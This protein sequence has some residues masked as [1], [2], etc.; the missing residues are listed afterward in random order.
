[1][2]RAAAP[3]SA[4]DAQLRSAS[5]RSRLQLGVWWLL[6]LVGVAVVVAG[7]LLDAPRALTGLGAVAVTSAYTWGLVARTGGRQLVFSMLAAALG[8]TA[9]VTDSEHLRAGAAVLTCTVGAVLGVMATQ[10][11][12]RFVESAREVVL[13]MG[14]A[15]LGAVAAVGYAPTVSLWRFEYVTLAL[16]F[17]VVLT[18]VYRLGAGLHG[19]GRR[20]VGVVVVSTLVVG[21][22]LAYGEALRSLGTSEISAAV[23]DVA[24]WLSA[25][26][27][28]VPRPTQAHVG[29]PA[30]AWGVYLR[31][32]RRQGWWVCGFGVAATAPVG[33]SLMDP[34][35]TLSQAGLGLL[36]SI[37]VGL[38]I[39]Y[40]LIRID[41]AL[42]GSKGAR[43]RR[44]ERRS[45]VRPEPARSRPLM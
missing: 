4:D 27:G 42:T 16:S 31:A 12:R 43:G 21:V 19:L 11:A 37:V 1:M 36:Y 22:V 41:L 40:V 23:D 15:V 2:R 17:V 10:P 26:L 18:L 44:A 45:A 3:R 39:A 20:G 24:D 13:A 6:L 30:L 35:A 9:V 34:A 29:V 38:L 33:N 7:E 8:V 28:A 14:V 5:A 32:R 25:T